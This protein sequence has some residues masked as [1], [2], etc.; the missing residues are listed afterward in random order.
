MRA[1]V[2]DVHQ[3]NRGVI[4]NTAFN[5]TSLLQSLFVKDDRNIIATSL[6]VQFYQRVSGLC[7]KSDRGQ[8]TLRRIVPDDT[9][10]MSD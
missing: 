8:R 1:G 10:S 3:I 7:R 5:A 6:N 2:M 4:V 9:A